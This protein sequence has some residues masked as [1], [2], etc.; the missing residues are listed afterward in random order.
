MY[1]RCCQEPGL[2]SLSESAETD[3]LSSVSV[4]SCHQPGLTCLSGECGNSCLQLFPYS[5]GK[6]PGLMHIPLQKALF[7]LRAKSAKIG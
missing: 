6:E 1:S 5:T 4:L 7:A 2:M 3:D